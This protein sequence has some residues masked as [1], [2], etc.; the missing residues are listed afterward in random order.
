MTFTSH[1]GFVGVHSS[2]QSLLKTCE[3]E[4]RLWFA[5]TL[6]FPPVNSI[7]TKSQVVFITNIPLALQ[8]FYCN[9]TF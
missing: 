3:W 5:C 6:L 9:V 1:L 8:A 2:T 4:A 7:I